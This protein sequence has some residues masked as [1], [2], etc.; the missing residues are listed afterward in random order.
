MSDCTSARILAKQNLDFLRGG[1][2]GDVEVFGPNAKQQ[3]SDAATDQH[4][5]ITGVGQT[6]C[7]VQSVGI[8]S[9]AGDSVLLGTQTRRLGRSFAQELS[10]RGPR[11]RVLVRGI[12]LYWLKKQ[13]LS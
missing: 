11:L 4:G 8:N 1:A 13:T 2:G 9:F 5:L 3:V 10:R 7:N 6:V 12:L